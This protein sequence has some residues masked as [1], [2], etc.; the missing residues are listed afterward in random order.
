[1]NHCQPS[2]DRYPRTQ[3]RKNSAVSLSMIPLES[4]LP[5]STVA[6]RRIKVLVADDVEEITE[7]IARWLEGEGHEV[8]KVAGGR[9]VIELVQQQRYDI[10][11]VDIVM[12]GVDGWDVILAVSRIR[13]ETLILAISGGGKLTPV[14]ACLRVAKGVGADLVLKKPFRQPEFLDAF[15]RLAARLPPLTGAT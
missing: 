5:E 1:M 3:L 14:E 8:T 7:L 4:P 12:P 9:E 6:P 2:G 15:G 13:P 11:V 10:L